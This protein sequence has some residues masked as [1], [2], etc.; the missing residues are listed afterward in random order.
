MP[1]AAPK[2]YDRVSPIVTAIETLPQGGT[3]GFEDITWEEY[4]ALLDV[5]GD[6]C[7]SRINYNTGR[8]EIMSP[9]GGHDYYKSLLG[10]LVE[11]LTEELDQSCVSLGSAT[12]R[13]K[14][15]Q[16]GTEPDECFFITTAD[17]M[18][19]RR[20]TEIK[21]DLPPDLV[22]EVDLFHQSLNK[23]PVYAEL[24]VPELWRFRDRKMHFYR[25]LAGKYVEIQASDLFP[26][27]TPDVLSEILSD[28]YVM[29]INR[30]KR[31]FRKWVR[32]NMPK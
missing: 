28:D 24:G 22:I 6:N 8:L 12:F 18:L 20:S 25:L 1:V 21:A 19:S 16:Q 7:H 2:R 11:V 13:K 14:E 23:F 29:D 31:A 17:K 27:L 10:S 3:L 4:E 30:V 9:S 32:E 5:L 15:K 26:F